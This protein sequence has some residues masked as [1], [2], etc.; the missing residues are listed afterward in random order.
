VGLKSIR[1]L[2][3]ITIF[4]FLGSAAVVYLRVTRAA[5][6]EQ[7][8]VP[9]EPLVPGSRSE[10]PG[11]PALAAPSTGIAGVEPAI[12]F[13]EADV[14]S[15]RNISFAYYS[16]TARKVSLMGD[17]NDWVPQPM[18]KEGSSWK[19]VVRIPEGTYLYNFLVDGKTV[20]DPGNKRPTQISSQGFKSSVLVLE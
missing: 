7:P 13:A 5:T 19:V 4:A 6:L 12:P 16:K 10:T 11:T 1:V 17:F 8:P 3:V 2:I 15:L 18:V 14:P 20:T 9:V